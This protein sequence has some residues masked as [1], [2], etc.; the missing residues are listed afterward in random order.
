[1]WGNLFFAEKSN[2]VKKLKIGIILLKFI[3]LELFPAIRLYLFLAKGAR[4]RIPLL[5]GLGL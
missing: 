1:L 5:S 3:N 2:F 4:K